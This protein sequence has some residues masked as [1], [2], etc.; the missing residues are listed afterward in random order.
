M[1]I[2]KLEGLRPLYEKFNSLNSPRDMWS[3]TSDRIEAHVD[4]YLALEEINV[5]PIIAEYYFSGR[6]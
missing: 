5:D 4:F 3:K 2:E 6:L 1:L